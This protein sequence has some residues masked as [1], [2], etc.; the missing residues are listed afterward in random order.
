VRFS[1]RPWQYRPHLTLQQNFEKS[2]DQGFFKENVRY[3]IWIF[4]PDFSDSRDQWLI[5]FSDSRDRWLFSLILGTRFSSLG[6]RIGSLKH[7][8][9]GPWSN[10]QT[11]KKLSWEYAKDAFTC[12]S[13]SR[14]HTT[15]ILVK[16]FGECCVS[17]VL[18][19][20]CY[21]PSSH[22]IPAQTC[23]R[24]GRVT[25]RPFTV[26]VGVRQGCVLSPLLFMVNISGY[27]KY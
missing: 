4:G 10:T 18:T 13:T 22:C 24:F 6:T 26:G 3:L 15:G 20:A 25:S 14:K 16:S 5:I 8:E 2:W 9:S 12:L 11:L 23:V 17:T 21:W 7:L 19:A 1:S 27:T